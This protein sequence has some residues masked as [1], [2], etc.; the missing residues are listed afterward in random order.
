MVHYVFFYL[1]LI[2]TFV[3]AI[4][5]ALAASKYDM[6]IFGV[7]LISFITACGGG[8]I[9][10]VCINQFPV[11]LHDINY[12]Y[13][14]VLAI[15][16]VAF[17]QKALKK[18]DYPILFFDA[19]GLGFFVVFGAHKVYSYTQSI[20]ISIVLGM[21]TGIGGGMLRDVFLNRVPTV[22]NNREIYAFAGLVGASIQV[23]AEVKFNQSLYVTCA[24][25]ILC[26]GIRLLSL[27][28]KIRVPIIK[29]L[30]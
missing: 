21:I 1:D 10:D 19:L 17:F 26:T 9:R 18:L 6:D 3:F 25:I 14:I 29:S 11:G 23:L 2:G 4:S 28:Y 7:L 8:I 15:L 5:G 24:G 20:E 16:L 22:L 12:L 13:A 30:S 27:K